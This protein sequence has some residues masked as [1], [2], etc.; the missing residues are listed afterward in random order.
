VAVAGVLVTGLV[1]VIPAIDFGI[2][3]TVPA[4]SRLRLIL[5]IP[6]WELVAIEVV[7]Q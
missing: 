3:W 5:V 4:I 1:T 2:M 7:K 6:G